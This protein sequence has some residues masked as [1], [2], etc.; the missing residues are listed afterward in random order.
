MA[1]ERI[2][3][4]AFIADGTI[5]QLTA[6]LD[7]GMEERALLNNAPILIVED[8]PFIALE[9]GVSVEE[10]G[11]KVVGPAASIRGALELLETS[12]IAGAILDIQLSDGEITPVA[13][14]LVRR[15]IPV[16]L[17]SGI[18]PPAALKQACPDCVIYKKPMVADVLVEELANLIKR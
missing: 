3:R 18:V 8:E 5:E 6:W 1:P 12:V 14:A 15:G 4:R 9:L 17:Q 11:G 13:Q 10:A 16:I 2:S 7:N